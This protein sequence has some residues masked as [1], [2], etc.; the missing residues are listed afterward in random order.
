M[1]DRRRVEFVIDF[2]PRDEFKG[3]YHRQQRFGC[4]VAHRRCGKTVA[5]ITDT[6]LR[7]LKTGKPNARYAY[8]APLYKQAKDIAW[9]YVRDFTAGFRGYAE[10]NEAELR[11]TLPNNATV[12][13]YGADNPDALRGIYL[14]GVVLDEY[15]LIDPRLWPE[16]IRPA[17]ADR[18]G[19]AVFIGTPRGRDAFYNIWREAQK[20]PGLW[21]AKMLR[22][23]DTNILPDSELDLARSE[24]SEAQYNREF[25]C[26]F[27]EAG[28]D[29]FISALAVQQAIE[30]DT[31]GTG[32]RLIGVDVARFGDDRSVV[33]WRNG[34]KLDA[35]ETYRGLDLMRT[36]GH[37]AQHID[38][39]KPEATFID[40][41]GLGSGVVDRLRQLGYGGIIEVHGG[42]KPWDDQLYTN[43][44]AEMWGNMRKWI[45][46]RAS[47]PDSQ[48]L[49][50]DLTCLTYSYDHANRLKLESKKDLKARG[51]PS[52]DLADGLALTFAE[53]IAPK[54][55]RVAVDVLE[56]AAE[57]SPFAEL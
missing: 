18:Q 5:C 13:L 47:L 46:D 57:E 56:T 36:A 27:D 52:P 1:A 24:M 48:E 30:R 50:D 38:R 20:D 7:A 39:Y 41:T 21:F 3:F 53:Q 26:S 6:I 35:T 19:W 34:D 29:Q 17:L 15:A 28:V 45:E 10:K 54:D 49:T 33:V 16:V 40:A 11:V 51:M 12:R 37:V 44:R 2:Q 4:I 31:P 42:S 32:P 22:A 8:I 23:S 14:D 55:F 43:K 25:E 9:Q